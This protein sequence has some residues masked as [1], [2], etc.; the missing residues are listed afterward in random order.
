[1]IVRRRNDPVEGIAAPPITIGLE[2]RREIV[3][4]YGLVGIIFGDL[5]HGAS[6]QARRPEFSRGRTKN[7][8]K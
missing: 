3:R 7:Q 8:E 6:P 4:G 1:V 2:H 5:D